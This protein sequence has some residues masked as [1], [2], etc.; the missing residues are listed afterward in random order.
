MP[1]RLLKKLDSH[2]RRILENLLT[3]VNIL[4]THNAE[5]HEAVKF[6][7]LQSDFYRAE[8]DECR[9]ETQKSLAAMMLLKSEKNIE[10]T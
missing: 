10:N 1:D 8:M 6:Y 5:L 9:A 2:D 4:R 7:Q 3:E